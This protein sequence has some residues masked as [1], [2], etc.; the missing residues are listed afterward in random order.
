MILSGGQKLDGHIAAEVRV[1]SQ[2]DHA[3]ATLADFVYEP[4]M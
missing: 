2:V 1:F 4:I 3:H